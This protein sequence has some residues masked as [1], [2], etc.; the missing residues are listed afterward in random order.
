MP[1][2]V[3]VPLFIASPAAARLCLSAKLKVGKWRF[4]SLSRLC[5]PGGDAVEDAF[6]VLS[7]TFPFPPPPTTTAFANVGELSGLNVAAVSAVAELLIV[8]KLGLGLEG[9][10]T[11][12][13][14]LF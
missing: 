12:L 3:P 6:D 1:F 10:P 2:P 8:R 14:G 7:T 5:L 11:T 4:L 13:P 9:L